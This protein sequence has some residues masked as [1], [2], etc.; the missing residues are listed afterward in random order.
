MALFKMNFK[1]LFNY[2]FCQSPEKSVIYIANCL[3]LV[4]TFRCSK[5]L[6]HLSHCKD[7]LCIS[8]VIKWSQEQVYFMSQHLTLEKEQHETT[9]VSIYR[10][11]DIQYIW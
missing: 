3:C 10:L 9:R 11:Y 8:A 4:L 6:K 1:I 2:L 7:D 5:K